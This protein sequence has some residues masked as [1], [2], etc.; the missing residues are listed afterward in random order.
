MASNLNEPAM[1]VCQACEGEGKVYW[2]F[3]QNDPEPFEKRCSHCNGSG[4]VAVE[5]EQADEDWIA[6]PGSACTEAS[7]GYCGRCT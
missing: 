7:C 6:E 5:A 1:D 2:S 3:H 4:F